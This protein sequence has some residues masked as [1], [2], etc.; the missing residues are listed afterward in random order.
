[1][2]EQ[3]VLFDKI[4]KKAKLDNTST[5]RALEFLSNKGIVILG[6]KEDKIVELGL[7]GIL[8]LKKGLPER[9]LINLISKSKGSI[10]INDALKESKLNENEFKA[11]LGSLKKRALINIINSNIILSGKMEEITKKT[12]EERF[13]EKLSE[14][15]T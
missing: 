15:T 13:L 6:K 4:T 9:N 5:L 10:S 11:A 14:D 2:K 3:K 1:M 8:Y 12:L 7:N